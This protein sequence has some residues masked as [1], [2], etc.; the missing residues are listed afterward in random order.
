MLYKNER[1]YYRINKKGPNGNVAPLL[2]KGV[3]FITDFKQHMD[4]CSNFSSR[5]AKAQPWAGGIAGPGWR[6]IL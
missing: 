6:E 4:L 5:I 3:R 1:W 2:E